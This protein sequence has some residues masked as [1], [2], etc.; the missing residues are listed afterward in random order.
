MPYILITAGIP[1]FNCNEYSWTKNHFMRSSFSMHTSRHIIIGGGITGLT[2]A[3]QLQKRY[4]NAAQITL[5]EKNRLGGWLKTDQYDD[6]LFERG[7]HSCRS[8]GGGESVL[9]L[10]ETLGLSQELIHADPAASKRY[11]YL[12]KKLTPIPSNPLSY[13]LSP[14][15]RSTIPSLLKEWSIPPYHEEESV[16]TWATRRLGETV[17]KRFID[18]LMRGI[19]AGDSRLLSMDACFPFLVAKER[20]FG[21]LTR[22]FFSPFKQHTASRLYSPWVNQMLARRIFTL[23]RGWGSLVERL[24]AHLSTTVQLRTDAELLTLYPHPQYKNKIQLLLQNQETLE[25]DKVYLTTPAYASACVLKPTFPHVAALL[26]ATPFESVLVAHVGFQQ[27]VLNYKGFGHLVPTWEDEEVLGMVWDSSLFPQ[28]NIH[29]HQTRL[30]IMLKSD[31]RDAENKIRQ[32]LFSHL[33]IT[34]KPTL[35]QLHLLPNAIAQYTLGHF[36]RLETI[37]NHLKEM[38]QIELLGSSLEGISLPACVN[39]ARQTAWY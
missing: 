8:H 26:N 37:K 23:R 21:S 14:L 24:I 25:A 5:L 11:L 19:F 38:P 20:F 27:P 35:L 30:T 39:Q 1:R 13:L 33:G 12:N 31:V 10:I 7:P 2:L 29:P 36:T 9:E 3:L 28:Q 4:G 22:S 6:F 34:A 18:P 16:H 15:T 32:I 17:A